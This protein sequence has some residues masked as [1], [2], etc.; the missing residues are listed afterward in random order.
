[1]KFSEFQPINEA[2]DISSPAKPVPKTAIKPQPNPKSPT[3]GGGGSGKI[4]RAPVTPDQPDVKNL[5]GNIVPGGVMQGVK[6]A[7]GGG[8]NYVDTRRSSNPEI[9]GTKDPHNMYTTSE[10]DLYSIAGKKERIKI[11]DPE[12]IKNARHD[13][14]QRFMMQRSAAEKKNKE[15][16]KRGLNS[17]PVAVDQHGV[18]L[19]FASQASVDARNRQKRRQAFKDDNPRYDF[20]QYS[21][22]EMAQIKSDAAMD[23]KTFGNAILDQIEKRTGQVNKLD[24]SHVNNG[25]GGIGW[26]DPRYAYDEIIGDKNTAKRIEKYRDAD[27]YKQAQLRKFDP[28]L[29]NFNRVDPFGDN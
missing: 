3:P 10:P 9:K 22:E 8:K 15:L 26:T 28:N 7:T 25:R 14:Q 19:E 4:A 6:Y 1:M 2:P 29:I 5:S 23:T 16:V 11:T 17:V 21:P 13:D 12:K 24:R 18:G 20:S 27:P